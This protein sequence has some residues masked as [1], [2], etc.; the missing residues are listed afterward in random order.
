MFYGI[1]WF[2][3]TAVYSVWQHSVKSNEGT[4]FLL[5]YKKPEW[6]FYVAFMYGFNSHGINTVEPVHTCLSMALVK[7]IEWERMVNQKT[8]KCDCSLMTSKSYS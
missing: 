1:G 7:H 3:A 2:T 5:S 8:V 6:C 4:L